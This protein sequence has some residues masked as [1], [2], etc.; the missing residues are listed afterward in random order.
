MPDQRSEK[1]KL[2]IVI[3]L[4][5]VAAIFAY[6]RFVHKKTAPVAEQAPSPV[7]QNQLTIPDIRIQD[8]LERQRETMPVHES[9]RAIARDIFEPFRFPEKPGPQPEEQKPEEQKPEAAEPAPSFLLKGTIVGGGNPIAI[10]NDQ[11]VRTGERIGD[12]KV[13]RIRENEVLLDSGEKK[14]KLEMVKND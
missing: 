8:A 4:A 10:I 7:S 5:I 9:L 3:V 11:F 13:V 14:I 12:F 6:F 2:Y 1:I